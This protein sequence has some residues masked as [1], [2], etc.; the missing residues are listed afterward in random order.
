M[1]IDTPTT[2]AFGLTLEA[3]FDAAVEQVKAALKTEGFGVLTEID[4]RRTLKDRLGVEVPDYVIL[5]A[6][7]P[8]LAHRALSIEPEVG[9]LLPC[10]VVVRAEGSTTSVSIMDPV[11]ALGIADIAEIKPV[12]EEAR[13]RLLRVVELLRQGTREVA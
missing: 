8:P 9:L 7:N 4:V 1:V 12:A 6:C 5:G 11:A 13:E 3:P 10:N 2:W